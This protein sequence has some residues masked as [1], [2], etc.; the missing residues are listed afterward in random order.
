MECPGPGRCCSPRLCTPEDRR[1]PTATNE[2]FI[3]YDCP[4]ADGSKGI[5]TAIAGVCS[6]DCPRADGSKSI[7]TAIAGVRITNIAGR[8][9]QLVFVGC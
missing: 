9:L 1:R 7:A 2:N 4:R 6:Y 5:A 3:S 8:L